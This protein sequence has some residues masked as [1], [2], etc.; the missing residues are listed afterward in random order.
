MGFQARDVFAVEYDP[1]GI[2]R[3]D[4]GYRIESCRLTST[5]RTDEGVDPLF[6]HMERH[7]VKSDQPSK[8]FQKVFHP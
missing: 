4:P 6:C 7:M 5:V 1:S 3:V 2:R 8:A